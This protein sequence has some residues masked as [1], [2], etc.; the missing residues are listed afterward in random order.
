MCKLNIF[1]F[2]V[3]VKGQNEMIVQEQIMW[4][5]FTYLKG[6]SEGDRSHRGMKKPE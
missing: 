5:G 2:F 3:L 1:I 6:I 4:T